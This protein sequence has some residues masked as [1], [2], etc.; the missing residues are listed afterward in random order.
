MEEPP[1][2]LRS[3]SSQAARGIIPQM[4]SKLSRGGSWRVLSVTKGRNVWESDRFCFS[5]AIRAGQELKICGSQFFTCRTEMLHPKLDEIIDT[6]H[7]P[8][9]N[10]K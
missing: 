10:R 3:A 5:R 1:T 6:P 7:L 8:P 4:N 9:C 2:Q